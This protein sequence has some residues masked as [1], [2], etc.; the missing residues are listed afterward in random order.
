MTKIALGCDHR[1]LD[2]MRFLEPWLTQNGYTVEVLCENSGRSSDY[3]DS[4][5][6]VGAAV[7]ENRADLGILLCGTGIG[8]CMAANKVRGVRAALVSDELTAQMSRAHNNANV[9]CVSADLL[10]HK[11]IQRIVETWLD[12]PFEGGR[13]A[14]RVN[15]I[16]AIE[17]G[18]DPR[19]ITDETLR[20]ANPHH[21][22]AQASR[23]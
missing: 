15:K 1:G 7:S 10:G 13:H 22:V 6:Q 18:D 9:L 3:P 16:I 17:R 4:A 12:T 20:D 14:R 19:A 8:M 5:Y 11:L 2:G 21:Q 23:L